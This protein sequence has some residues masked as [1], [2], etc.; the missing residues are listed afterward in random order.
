MLASA[1]TATI[2]GNGVRPCTVKVLVDEENPYTGIPGH[3][4]KQ[5]SWLT[6]LHRAYWGR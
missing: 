3:V 6:V 4:A 2:P 5:V 1:V